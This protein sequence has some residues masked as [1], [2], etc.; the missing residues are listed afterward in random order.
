MAR[1]DSGCVTALGELAR[2]VREADPAKADMYAKL[3][4]TLTRQPEELLVET[5]IQPCLNMRK[6]FVSVSCPRSKA[7]Q[8]GVMA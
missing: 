1:P 7:Y 2:V 8:L 5:T 4:L 3:R 6:G